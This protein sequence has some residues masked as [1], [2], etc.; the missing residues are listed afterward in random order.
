MD[1]GRK[2]IAFQYQADRVDISSRCCFAPIAETGYA[3][4]TLSYRFF[5]SNF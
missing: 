2:F 3:A 4:G 1:I 5:G